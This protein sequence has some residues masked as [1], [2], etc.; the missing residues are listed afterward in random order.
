MTNVPVFLP[1]QSGLGTV[2]SFV[3]CFL[4]SAVF[5][6]F[7]VR[8]VLRYRAE[9]R[10]AEDAR[11][12]ADRR[13]RSLAPGDAILLGRVEYAQGE[14]RAV[15]VEIRQTGS[16]AE[17]S[18]GWSHSWSE[19]GRTV[20]VRPFYL[21]LEGGERVRVEPREQEVR[22]VDEMD[23]K[24]LVHHTSRIRVAELT[25]DEQVYACGR[26]EVA[27]DPEGAGGGY[28]AAS[29][30][31]LRAGDEPMILSSKPLDE[32]FERRAA[33]QGWSISF[34]AANLLIVL[35]CCTPYLWSLAF[36]HPSIGTV[37][38][39]SYT[40]HTNS[41]GEAT[42]RYWARV[43]PQSSPESSVALEV[44][45]GAYQILKGVV[46][47]HAEGPKDGEPLPLSPV[48]PIREV[49]STVTLGPAA[50]VERGWFSALLALEVGI[51]VVF[52]I[53]ILATRASLRAWHDPGAKLEEAG[54]GRLNES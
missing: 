32:G 22:I 24:I 20:I 36:G 1:L 16:E 4:P 13:A 53:A 31:V 49:S 50:T 18:G 26:L 10:S 35:A 34:F 54:R 43:A 7:L 30:F 33:K 3:V 46:D 15:R 45:E 42:T 51:F 48:V 23:G 39:T 5:A 9:K 40:V 6:A 38:A 17:G 37:T 11:A 12:S 44:D 47:A 2:G 41:D 21:R 8:A 27:A 19:V 52:G 28:R 14:E 29:G 25:P